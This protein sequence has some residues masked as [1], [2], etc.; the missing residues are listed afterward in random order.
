MRTR[1]SSPSSNSCSISRCNVEDI[2]LTK[3]RVK[4]TKV[5]MRETVGHMIDRLMHDRTVTKITIFKTA[6]NRVLKVRGS[7]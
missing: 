5:D 7:R 1:G 2:D 6:D 3:E 4:P